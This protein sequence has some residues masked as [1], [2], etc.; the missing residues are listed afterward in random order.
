MGDLTKNFSWSEFACKCGCG[1]KL[2]SPYLVE[3]LQEIRAIYG[4]PI[5]INSAV[6]CEKHNKDEDGAEDSE[7]LPQDEAAGFGQG[8]DIACEN[9][10]DRFELLALA[11]EKVDGERRFK[12]VGIGEDFLHFGVKRSKAQNVVWLYP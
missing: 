6:R 1:A 7:H 2:I 9:S 10:G 8:V 3:T 5:K 4:K 11:L 12:R